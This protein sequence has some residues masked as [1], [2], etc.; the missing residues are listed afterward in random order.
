MRVRINK[1]GPTDRPEKPDGVILQAVPLQVAG[2]YA[3]ALAPL[4][5]SG[6]VLLSRTKQSLNTA[7]DGL[8]V[9]PDDR[10]T[11]TFVR[12]YFINLSGGALRSSLERL[13]L[14]RTR[15]L[16]VFMGFAHRFDCVAHLPCAWRQFRWASRLQ[17]PDDLN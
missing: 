5:V 4:C 9:L 2:D 15:R 10:F 13:L 7:P 3:L 6:C 1:F 17:L 16:E 12:G 11:K 8:T 14:L